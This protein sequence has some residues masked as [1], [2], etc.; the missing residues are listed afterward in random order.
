MK[1]S[2]IVYLF[3]I[4]ILSHLITVTLNINNLNNG[5]NIVEKAFEDVQILRGM[6]WD[7]LMQA[8]SNELIALQNTPCSIRLSTDTF[9][10]GIIRN[11]IGLDGERLVVVIETNNEGARVLFVSENANRDL[12]ELLAKVSFAEN[13][14]HPNYLTTGEGDGVPTTRH[15]RYFWHSVVFVQDCQEESLVVLYGTAELKIL[16]ETGR[17]HA[18]FRDN[19]YGFF[20][21]VQNTFKV[22]LFSIVTTFI[23][24]ISLILLLKEFKGAGSNVE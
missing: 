8:Q 22:L 4:L 2:K 15:D 21:S 1:N 12:E 11:R 7:T 19:V 24:G 13:V 20:N 6:L 17:R 16:Q 14:L 5:R 18:I 10:R 3:I 23:V 9:I